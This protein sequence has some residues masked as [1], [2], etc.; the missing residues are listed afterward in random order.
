MYDDD[1]FI[2]LRRKWY[3]KAKDSGFDDIEIWGRKKDPEPLL[4]GVSGGD[5]RRGLYK[6]ETEEYY[7]LARGHLW[8]IEDKRFRLMWSMHSEGQSVDKIYT[9][10]R[11]FLNVSKA[12]VRDYLKAERIRMFQKVRERAYEQADEEE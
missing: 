5:L 1:I 11:G 4:Y 9:T 7:T 12:T 10:V 2:R 3:Q 6:P 8:E